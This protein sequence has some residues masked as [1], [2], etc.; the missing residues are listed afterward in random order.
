MI[1]K[2]NFYRQLILQ[3]KKLILI[4]EIC[5]FVSRVSPFK[6]NLLS[7]LISFF[8]STYMGSNIL[9]T[10]TQLVDSYTPA[11]GANLGFA[12]F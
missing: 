4:K 2:L 7:C 1:L 9:D 3:I 5:I 10:T 12:K 6:S 11:T 8:K